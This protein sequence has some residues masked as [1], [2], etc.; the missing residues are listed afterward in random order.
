MKKKCGTKKAGYKTV[1]VNIRQGLKS[2]AD[3]R[4][5]SQY[6]RKRAVDRKTTVETVFGQGKTQHLLRRA[7]VRGLEK[8]SIQF[9]M[10]AIAM[11]IKRM[12]KSLHGSLKRLLGPRN[13]VVMALWRLILVID[14]KVNYSLVF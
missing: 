1:Q 12:V 5:W 14:G 6:G 2:D 10:S 8:V 7:R 3:E 13:P 4:C 9:L 11:N